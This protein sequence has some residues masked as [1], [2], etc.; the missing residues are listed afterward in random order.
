MMQQNKLHIITNKSL[1]D[2]FIITKYEYNVDTVSQIILLFF[3][4][5][6]NISYNRHRRLLRNPQN[7]P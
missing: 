7:I 4:N 2:I 1:I 5:I 6:T 3:D